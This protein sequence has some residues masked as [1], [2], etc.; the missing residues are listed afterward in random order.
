MWCS[1]AR[2]ER[3]QNGWKKK[4]NSKKG[5]SKKGKKQKKTTQNKHTTKQNT[6]YPSFASNNASHMPSYFVAPAVDSG[7]MPK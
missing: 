5:G 1:I 6:L 4:K 2:L 7:M 3:E